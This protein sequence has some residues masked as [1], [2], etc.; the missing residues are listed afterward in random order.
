MMH[1]ETDPLV[2]DMEGVERLLRGTATDASMAG[3]MIT[4]S[5]Q[6][7]VDHSDQL[8]SILTDTID[9]LIELE[10]KVAAIEAKS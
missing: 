10:A 8:A 4:A 2:R 9:R 3:D 6:S 1:S 5:I 7:L